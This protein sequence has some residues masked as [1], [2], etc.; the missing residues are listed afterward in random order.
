MYDHKWD[1]FIRSLQAFKSREGHCHVPKKHV[2]NG[3]ALGQTVRDVRYKQCYVRDRPDRLRMLKDMGFTE[4][5]TEKRWLVFL[6]ALCSFRSREGHSCVPHDHTE[7]GYALGKAVLNVQSRKAFVRDHP[8]RL[9][10]LQDIGFVMVSGRERNW[11]AFLQALNSFRSREGHCLAPRRHR[12]GDYNLG[13]ALD[14]VRY[15]GDYLKGRPERLRLL[16]NMAFFNDQKTWV[17]ALLVNACA[18]PESS[19]FAAASTLR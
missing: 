10:T 15:R 12:E 2:E 9:R 16:V 1:H 18:N 7:N 3:Y 11:L 8:D 6:N 19:I 17:V 5:S 14:R 13:Q 4:T